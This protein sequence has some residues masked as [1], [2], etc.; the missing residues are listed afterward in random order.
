MVVE[1][2]LAQEVATS[3]FDLRVVSK[4]FNSLVTPL[5]YRHIILNKRIIVSL[6]SHQATLSPHKLQV[7]HDIRE[8]TW[9]VTLQGDFPEEHLGS[10]FG[11][12]KHLREVT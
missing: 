5:L 11:S 1:I 3:F 7:A 6:V 10:V 4:Q 2:V 9:H 12:L 8:Y